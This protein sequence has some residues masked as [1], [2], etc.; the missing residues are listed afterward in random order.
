M[1][2]VYFIEDIIN[3]NINLNIFLD[4]TKSYLFSLYIFYH[5]S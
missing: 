3:L 1:N 4:K 2:I 5:N